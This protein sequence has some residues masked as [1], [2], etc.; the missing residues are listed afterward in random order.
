MKMHTHTAGDID[1]TAFER[2][3]LKEIGMPEEIVMRHR[4]PHFSHLFSSDSYSAGYY[5]YLWS[6]ALTADAAEV[7]E[8]SSGGYYDPAVAK[9]LRDNVLS[10]GDTIDPAE[11]FRRFRGR[12]VD[13]GALLRKRGFPTE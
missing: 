5:S 10:V 9:S 8:E 13:T 6:D 1:P 2:Q 7:F 12:D 11:S 4:T 3:T